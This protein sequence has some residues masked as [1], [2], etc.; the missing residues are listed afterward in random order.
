MA[1]TSLALAILA[2]LANLQKVK[3]LWNL[4]ERSR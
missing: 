3:G 4:C 2:P 1:I